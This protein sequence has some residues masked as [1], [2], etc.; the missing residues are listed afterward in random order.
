MYICRMQYNW[1]QKAGSA[2][3]APVVGKC[4]SFFYFPTPVE[5]RLGDKIIKTKP[6]AC[7]LNKPG[8]PRNFYFAQDTQMHWIHA[9]PAFSELLERYPIETET[10]LYPE[11]SGFLPRMF[12]DIFREF[13]MRQPYREDMVD[14][15]LTQMVIRLSRALSEN[16]SIHSVSLENR[17]KIRRLHDELLSKPERK[18][19]VAEMAEAVYL[20]PSRFHSAYKAMYQSSPLQDVIQARVEMAKELLCSGEQYTLPVLAE[21]LGYKSQYHFIEQFKSVTGM[22]PGVY[23]RKNR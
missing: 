21:R 23:R 18:W 7:L 1:L 22:T 19:T 11:D 9:Y 5:V 12:R 4:Y 3:T 6:H 2:I 15:L 13:T 17:Q 14:C 20:S 8:Q 16:Q 10:L